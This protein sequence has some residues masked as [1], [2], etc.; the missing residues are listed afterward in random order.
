[1]G[2]HTQSLDYNNFARVIGYGGND[3]YLNVIIAYVCCFLCKESVSERNGVK[4]F[5]D[6]VTKRLEGKFMYG[7]KIRACK[8]CLVNMTFST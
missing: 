5:V 6:Q 2:Y 7:G 8:T 4:R 3:T 1:M